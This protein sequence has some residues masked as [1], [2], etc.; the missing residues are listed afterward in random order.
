MQFVLQFYMTIN[1]AF[2]IRG[3]SGLGLEFS[4]RNHTSGVVFLIFFL[5]VCLEYIFGDLICIW[6]AIY[7]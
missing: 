3:R 5:R 7:I 1:K 2:Y 6:V 4:E